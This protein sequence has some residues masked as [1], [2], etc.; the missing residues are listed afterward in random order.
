MNVGDVMTRD[1]E[2]VAPGTSVK[3]VARLLSWRRISGVPVVQDGVPLGVVS[4]SDIVAKEQESEA[5]TV[6]LRRARLRRD[7]RRKVITAA[8]AMTTPPITVTPQTSAVGAARLMTERDVG[9][10]LV[11]KG[12]RLVGILTRSDLVRAFGRSDELIRT[13][14]VSEILPSLG[15]SPND[16]EV[17]VSDGNVGLDGEA[18]D[19]ID[20]RCLPHAVRAVLGVVD[21]RCDVSARHAHRPAEL[22]VP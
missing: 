13:E 6:G 18:E 4:Q 22:Y 12:K 10:L 15:L 11:V 3:E 14:I 17:R 16:I 20:A 5:E 2:T 21:V 9:R 7:R 8:D 19:E 1:V